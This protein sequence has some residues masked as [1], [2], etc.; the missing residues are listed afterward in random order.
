M[1]TPNRSFV[2][3]RNLQQTL[4]TN[5][6]QCLTPIFPFS[7][8]DS[9]TQRHNASK[10]IHA[11]SRNRLYSHQNTLFTMVLSSLHEDKSQQQSVN[12]FSD[13]A[14]ES[15]QRIMAEERN[16]YETAQRKA[17]LE[18]RGRGRPRQFKS[19]VP[20]S[21]RKKI[22]SNTA[23]Y[24]N[25][26]TRLPLALL[27]EVFRHTAE[28]KELTYVH[29]WHGR[30]VF[31]TDGTYFQMQDSPLIGKKY[32]SQ[33]TAEGQ[34]QGYPQGLLVLLTQHG[35]GLI[36]SYKM[37]G[38]A[39]SELSMGAHLV[40]DLPEK[41]LLLADAL[42]GAYAFMA[43]MSSAHKD[44]IVPDKQ[45]RK[46]RIL[47]NLAPGDDIIELIKSSRATGL[48][49]D[50]H[51]PKTLVVRRITYADTHNPQIR[52]A[53]LTSITDESIR[54]DEI[55][56][57]YACRWDVEITI[58]EIKTLMGLQVARSKSEEM[59]FK[60]IAAALI[61]YN[62][63]RYIITMAVEK[64]DFSPEEDFMQELFAY[65]APTFIDSLGR[66]YKKF[67]PGRPPKNHPA[68]QT[69]DYP[70]KTQ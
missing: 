5:L 3:T 67:S 42:Y 46:Y 22:S 14:M 2:I 36:R 40:A 29:R 21:M 33:Q 53:L 25:A 51:L 4:R 39:D 11:Q 57:K 30:E 34:L 17:E 43:L 18:G 41:S 44:F 60:E 70:G 31:N 9:F 56:R 38:R 64:T 48:I 52:H 54:A 1:T 47:K 28:P 66:T 69:K 32:R 62:L 59:V 10:S 6:L 68:N 7:V 55:I 20:V 49:K 19:S 27:T 13:V 8:V 26:R 15:A 45:I 63:I 12:L 58:R 61:A 23:S 35:T 37:A 16:A 50:Q 65:R 24:S